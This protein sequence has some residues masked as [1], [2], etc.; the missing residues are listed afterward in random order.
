[1]NII[2][3]KVIAEIGINYAYGHDSSKFV[4]NAI[5]LI[6]LA[7]DAGC[8]YVKFQKRNPEVSVPI[9][10]RD[11]VRNVPWSVIP[12]SYIQYKKDIE[13]GKYEFDIIETH[14]A[15]IGIK[16]FASVWDIDSVNFM[17][18]YD[19]DII[20]IPSAK[21]K[22][23]DLIEYAFSQGFRVNMLSTGMSN[24]SDIDHV[25]NSYRVNVIMHTT[26]AYP[27]EPYD[28]NLDYLKWLAV[29][30]PH[31]FIGYSGHDLGITL[32]IAAR[33]M[34]ASYIEKHFTSDKHLF[35]SDQHISIEYDELRE[36]VKSI[37]MIDSASGG[38][39]PRVILE[40][41]KLKEKTLK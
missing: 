25:L 21:L 26:S 22:D 13:F 15:M 36:L 40:S 24:E 37:H 23:A 16:W 17:K 2:K 34:G 6:N 9:H 38:Y 35:G 12:I 33:G 39:H 1:M 29:K 5:A 4:D 20:K 31:S 28:A 11:S 30:Y 3:T 8:D 18:H 7:K 14:C 10:M 41:E 27:T 32:S 19:P